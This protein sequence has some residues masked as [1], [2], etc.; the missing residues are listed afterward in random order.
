MP[1]ATAMYCTPGVHAGCSVAAQKETDVLDTKRRD[2][3]PYG[4]PPPAHR[5]PAATH[6]GGVELLVSDLARARTFYEQVLG[7]DRSWS[8][9]SRRRWRTRRRPAPGVAA[10][11]ARRHQRPPW[12]ARLVSLRDPAAGPRRTRALRGASVDA[13]RSRRHGRS[14]GQRSALSDGPRRPRHRGLR[15]PAT[16]HLAPASAL[17][18]GDVPEPDTEPH[19]DPGR[20]RGRRRPAPPACPSPTCCRAAACTS[21]SR[22]CRSCPGAEVAGVVR[23]APAGAGV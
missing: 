5:L 14:S 20:G 21:S 18:A 13:G 22:R 11:E 1:P 4:I 2:E 16:A 10:Y 6:I 3:L 8:A 12:G 17:A 9:P 23:S 15:G 19:D 7:C